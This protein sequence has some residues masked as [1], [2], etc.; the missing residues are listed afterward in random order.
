MRW[1][2]GPSGGRRRAVEG[3][4]GGGLWQERRETMPGHF[5]RRHSSRHKRHQGVHRCVSSLKR[6]HCTDH[7][8]FPF[9]A[10]CF[11]SE[12]DWSP[13]G[14]QVRTLQGMRYWGSSGV[15]RRSAGPAPPLA[16]LWHWRGSERSGVAGLSRSQSPGDWRGCDWSNRGGLRGRRR[17]APPPR[18]PGRTSEGRSHRGTRPRRRKRCSHA[19]DIP[20]VLQTD[21]G[22]IMV[23]EQWFQ[24][25]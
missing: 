5:P 17:W 23:T 20:N 6:G 25:H 3:V 11:R 16:P 24:T 8:V 14:Q 4:S 9:V 1:W 21:R 22:V 12:V 7:T 2:S 19:T 18:D 13:G 10:R 15:T